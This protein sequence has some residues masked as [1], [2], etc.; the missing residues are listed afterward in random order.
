MPCASACHRPGLLAAS[1]RATTATAPGGNVYV[2]VSGQV[3]FSVFPFFG[4]HLGVS[5]TAG[6]PVECFRPVSQN[7]AS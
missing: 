2:T 7:G 4:L 6:G 3:A 5:A 1:C